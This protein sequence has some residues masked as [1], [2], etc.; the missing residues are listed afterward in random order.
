MLTRRGIASVLALPIALAVLAGCSSSKSDSTTTS[1]APSTSSSTPTLDHSATVVADVSAALKTLTSVHVDTDTGTSKG[2]TDVTLS[3][4]EVTALHITT[5][6]DG[7]PVEAIYIG[8]TS[9]VKNDGDPKWSTAP[10]SPISNVAITKLLASGQSVISLIAAADNIT[11]VGTEQI[12]GVETSHYSMSIEPS[13]VST[14]SDIGQLFALLG[15]NPIPA[16]LWVDAQNLPRKISFTAN[17]LGQTK[18]ITAVLSNFNAPLTITA[19]DP[20][21]VNQ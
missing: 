7:K 2:S 1:S 15:K 16:E 10:L 3:N 11:Y 9:Y 14:S 17:V 5:T 19:P 4:G 8:D 21:Q 18:T 12:D 13:K 20:S 6:Q